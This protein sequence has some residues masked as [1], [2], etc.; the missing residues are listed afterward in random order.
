MISKLLTVT[1]PLNLLGYIL[2]S[3]IFIKKKISSYNPLAFQ[4]TREY[5]CVLQIETGKLIPIPL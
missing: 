1:R 5:F 4:R 3:Y 2:S